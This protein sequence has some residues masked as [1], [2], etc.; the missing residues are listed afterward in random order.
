MRKSILN[1]LQYRK[2]EKICK[3]HKYTFSSRNHQYELLAII[4]GPIFC[5]I[6]TSSHHTNISVIDKRTDT[7]DK[8]NLNYC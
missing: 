6:I 3:I 8:S 1:F 2:H 4:T 5:G 7:E